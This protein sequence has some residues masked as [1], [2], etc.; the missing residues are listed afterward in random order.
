MKR[1]QLK[2]RA[3]KTKSVDGLIKYKKQFN[4]V[5]KLKKSF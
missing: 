3:N 1:F 2:N 5:V 4:L